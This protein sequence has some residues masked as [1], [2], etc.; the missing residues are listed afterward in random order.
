EPVRRRAGQ[1]RRPHFAHYSYSAKAECEYYHPS[2]AAAVG[3]RG[4]LGNDQPTSTSV[5]VHGG[6]FLERTESGDYSLYL[7]LPRLP[8]G[9]GTI[10]EIEIES[11][12]GKRSYT[13]AQLQRPRFVPVMPRLPLA[14]V[15]GSGELGALAV[16]IKSDISRFRDMGNFFHASE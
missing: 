1:E 15:I 16:A 8:A 5:L 3:S 14:K 2:W 4:T 9:T 7:K 12:L 13:G 11:G 6:L 10:G